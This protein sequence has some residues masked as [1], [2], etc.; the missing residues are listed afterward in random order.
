MCKTMSV[1]FLGLFL[2]IGCSAADEE[3]NGHQFTSAEAAHYDGHISSPDAGNNATTV[4]T[5]AA[6]DSGEL[7]K[8]EEEGK[9]GQVTLPEVTP[10][11]QESL[12][13]NDGNICTT[14]ICDAAK[15]CVYQFYDYSCDDGAECTESSCKVGSCVSEPTICDDGVP[16]TL[17]S[18]DKKTGQCAYKSKCD[19]YSVGVLAKPVLTD[20]YYHF[21]R[22]IEPAKKWKKSGVQEWSH[23]VFDGVSKKMSPSEHLGGSVN[24]QADPSNYYGFCQTLFNAKKEGHDFSMLFQAFKVS[25]KDGSMTLMKPWELETRF[26]VASYGDGILKKTMEVAFTKLSQ[27]PKYI[28][29]DTYEKYGYYSMDLKGPCKPYAFNVSP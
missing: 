1:L 7:P 8:A 3:V 23:Y 16:C 2:L 5:S 12:D 25:Y 28:A 20:K 10:L 6:S 18:C 26:S 4:D 21:I 9:K 17:D 24:L 13:C 15:F 29:G 22:L 27:A 11:C 19:I 14:D